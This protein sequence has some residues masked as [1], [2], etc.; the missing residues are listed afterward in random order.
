MKQKKLYVVRKYIMAVDAREAIRLE[1][2]HPV[3][4]TYVDDDWKKANLDEPTK[5]PMGFKS[6]QS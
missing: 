2:S 1:H 3:D 5:P 4:E 6:K